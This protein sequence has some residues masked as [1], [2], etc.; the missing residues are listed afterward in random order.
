MS[1]S[2]SVYLNKKKYIRGK[3]FLQKNKYHHNRNR[4][5]NSNK[6]I[7]TNFRNINSNIIL[8]EKQNSIK[9]HFINKRSNKLGV[10]NM[11]LYDEISEDFSQSTIDS[12][13]A[14]GFFLIKTNID[15]YNLNKKTNINNINVQILLGY[16][17]IKK[18]K[19]QNDD[20]L[21]KE[22]NKV[23]AELNILGGKKDSTEFHPSLTAY[24][25]FSEENLYIYNMFL[26]YFSFIHYVMKN[27]TD[28]DELKN[29]E[30]YEDF[31][32]I[33]YLR[34]IN[35]LPQKEKERI[36]N[37]H[38]KNL[39]LFFREKCLNIKE[40]YDIIYK[41]S[42]PP[43]YNNKKN[44]TLEIIHEQINMYKKVQNT[45]K[46]NFKLYYK[47]GKYSLHFYN[48]IQYNCSNIL[49]YLNNFF[50]DNYTNFFSII[51][52][53][54]YDYLKKCR[55]D[56]GE[57]ESSSFKSR[58]LMEI[59][60]EKIYEDLMC[61]KDFCES[62]CKNKDENFF[63]FSSEKKKIKIDSGYMNNLKWLDISLILHFIVKEFYYLSIISSTLWD[64]YTKIIYCY[65][66][67]TNN[68][69]SILINNNNIH[70]SA[71]IISK[72]Y[73]L[74]KNFDG[75][76]RKFFQNDKPDSFFLLLFSPFNTKLN[77][78]NVNYINFNYYNL[79]MRRFFRDLI[80]SE[81]F[82]IFLFLN[83]IGS[84]PF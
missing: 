75:E 30:K 60:Y 32:K 66:K 70:L 53:E 58:D 2:Q 62:K 59:T 45:N 39:I 22:K 24:R 49:H 3:I 23:K 74:Y 16:D 27:I 80:L 84:I 42:Y 7:S 71:E 18:K 14:A 6:F 44:E 5:L 9:N 76:L 20:T 78:E 41:S 35:N 64:L 31:L 40:N 83:L 36:I 47:K 38:S 81:N 1:F 19:N 8:S 68:S 50:W 17:P 26:S 11:N 13:K 48:V 34:D 29:A 37:L 43:S 69:H 55:I 25:E 52:K 79:R 15:L 10:K 46:G 65:H 12:Y 61:V 72:V 56:S 77:H 82:W 73:N 4:Y 63:Q 51:V 67:G 21:Y 54:N 57:Y 28:T 33:N